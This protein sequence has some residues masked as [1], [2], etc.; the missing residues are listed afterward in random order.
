LH[1]DPAARHYLPYNGP[2][3]H[4]LQAQALEN[5]RKRQRTAGNS[6]APKAYKNTDEL[7]FERINGKAIIRA[8]DGTFLGLISD[9]ARHRDAIINGSGKYG[10]E[11]SST[12]IFNEAGP[13]GGE[14]SQT[15]PWNDISMRPPRVFLGDEF[16][17]FLTVN[18]LKTPRINTNTLLRHLRHMGGTMPNRS[19]VIAN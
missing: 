19:I 8:D 17:G 6:P 9:D 15:S 16:I 3:K 13:Y 5:D 10:S 4:R 18:D 11:V 2:D 7:T 12:S 1:D 14:I